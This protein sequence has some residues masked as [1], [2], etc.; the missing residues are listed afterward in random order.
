[1]LADSTEQD[2]DVVQGV[3]VPEAPLDTPGDI[4][5]DIMAWWAAAARKPRMSLTEC[6][7]GHARIAAVI[8]GV[9]PGTPDDV[10]PAVLLAARAIAE[11]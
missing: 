2:E 10:I 6:D 8:P 9:I 4:P 5:A 11:D 7:E 3:V 1:M